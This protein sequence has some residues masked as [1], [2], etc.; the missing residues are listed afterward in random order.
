MSRLDRFVVFGELSDERVVVVED[1][2]LLCKT[3]R[4]FKTFLI[5]QT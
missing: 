3:D 5:S 2:Q 1:E 4:Q